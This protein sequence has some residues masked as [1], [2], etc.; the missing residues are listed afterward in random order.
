[1]KRLIVI[2]GFDRCGKDTLLEDLEKNDIFVFK[3]D[4]EGLPKYDKEQDNFLEWLDN[5]IKWQIKTLNKLFEDHDI[6]VMSRFLVSDEV[7]SELFNRKHTV[8]EHIKDLRKDVMIF[9]YCLLFKDYQEY[10]DRLKIIHDNEIQYSKEDFDKIN[11]LYEK[12]TNGYFSYRKWIFSY[13]TRQEVLDNFMKIYNVI[14]GKSD[15][16]N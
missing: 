11:G 7:Y 2:E 3:N 5:Y 12:N 4:L 9:N 8:I 6:I 15:R 16:K 1:M 10:L 14:Y 13:N